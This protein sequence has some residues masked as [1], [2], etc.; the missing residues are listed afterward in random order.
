M[1][2]DLYQ[3]TL[4]FLISEYPKGKNHPA[5]HLGMVPF[6]LHI[7]IKRT[8][9]LTCIQKMHLCRSVDPDEFPEYKAEQ[10]NPTTTEPGKLT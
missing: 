7:Y 5:V 3:A 9:F 2:R 1:V 10:S 8:I 4:F 6:P